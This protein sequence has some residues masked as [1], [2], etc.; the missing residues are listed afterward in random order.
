MTRA[1]LM[2]GTMLAAMTPVAAWAGTG[3]AEAEIAEAGG[4]TITVTATRRPTAIENVPATVTVIDEEQIADQ[5]AGDIRDL[6]RFEPG[7]SV[8]RAPARFGA[9]L[10]STGRDVNSGFRIRG[11]GGNRVLTQVD[12]IR[13][14]DGF[15]F[16]AQ[17][18]GR[19]EYVD[20]GIVRSVEILRGPASALY[21][22]DGLAGAVSFQTSDPEDL[23]ADGRS[24]TGMLRAGFDSSSDEFTET[25]RV[26]GRSGAWSALVSYT[27]R[28]G[29]ELENQGRTDANDAT[30]TIPNPQDTRSNAVL[31]KIVFAP[32]DA[33][34]FRLAA[35]YGDSRIFTDVL[36]GRS[37]TVLDIYGRD[38]TERRRVSLD[39]RYNGGGAIDFAQIAVYWQDSENYQFTFEDREPA[40]DRTRINTFDNRVIG[41]SG[42]ARA[43]FATGPIGHNIVFGGDISRTHQEGLRDGTVPPAGETFPTRAFPETNYTLAGLFLG[44]EIAFG[45]G[46]FTLHPAVRF[47]HYDLNA[48]DDPLLPGF[49]GAD[50]SGSRVTPRIGAVWQLGRGISLYGNYAQG[51]KSPA[52]GQVN[53]FFQN[54]TS[55]FFSYVS[56]PNPDLRPE[57]SETWEAGIRYRGSIVSASLTGFVGRY[58]DFIS[59]EQIGGTGSLV[60]PIIYQF[61]NLNRVEIE[62]IEG[63][64]GLAFPSGFTADFAFAWATGD[65]VQ[66]DGTTAPL[67][68]IDPLKVVLGVGYRAP[69]GR[70]GG[71]LYLTHADRKSLGSTIGICAGDCFRPASSTVLDATAFFRFNDNFTLRAGLFNITDES[72]AYWSDVVG[73]SA[74][75]AAVD[76]YT[77]PGR[78][79]RVSLTARF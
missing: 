73:L 57:T 24:V 21:G 13:I 9:A 50:Q 71:N 41:A 40:V 64:A 34:R 5:L 69:G 58:D 53:Q 59:Q 62:G 17:I 4:Q 63:R 75:S 14:P 76:A 30:R 3:T 55:P 60:D 28:D 35:E 65:V 11:I 6:V 16:G 37:A 74:T 23:L 36:S 26:A 32:S 68:S 79:F 52:P 22:S 25:A 29:G 19:G 77:Q 20:L 54:L 33:H 18:T 42:E 56:L 72:Y 44:D 78:N 43:S 1:G 46:A 8:P 7:V 48:L 2:A 70:F 47:D 45:G 38:T 49:A 31:G 27:R 66:P 12:G 51:F 39:W 10:G 67:S 61:I 15:S